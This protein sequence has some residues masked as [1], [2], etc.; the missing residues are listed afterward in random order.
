MTIVIQLEENI[1]VKRKRYNLIYE[2]NEIKRKTVV[3]YLK[4]NSFLKVE[5]K[6]ASRINM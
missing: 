5:I 3:K 6:I 4:F 1:K 2:K